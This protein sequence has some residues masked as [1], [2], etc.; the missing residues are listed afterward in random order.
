MVVLATI[1]RTRIILP[2]LFLGVLVTHRKRIIS[3][4]CFLGVLF[5]FYVSE[6][7][8]LSSS[9]ARGKVNRGEERG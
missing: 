8:E 9:L 4:T 5:T 1:K 7:H 6:D 2:T 3:S